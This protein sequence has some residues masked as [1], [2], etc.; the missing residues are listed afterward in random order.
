MMEA[1]KMLLALAALVALCAG[2]GCVTTPKE[3]QTN[4]ISMGSLNL[5]EREDLDPKWQEIIGYD[6][7]QLAFWPWGGPEYNPLNPN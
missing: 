2:N 3:F 1:M 6:P 7:M 4:R 5:N